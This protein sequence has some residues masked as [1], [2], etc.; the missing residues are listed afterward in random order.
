MGRAGRAT[1]GGGGLSMS[2]PVPAQREMVAPATRTD[3]DLDALLLDIFFDQMPMGIAVFGTDLRLQRST[4]P[5]PGSSR[6]TS[7][8]RRSR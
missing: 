8:C 4:R 1:T 5:G 7:A 2:R 3:G 6:T